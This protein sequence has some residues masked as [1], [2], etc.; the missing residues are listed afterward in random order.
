MKRQVKHRQETLEQLWRT[1]IG[2][3]CSQ[4]TRSD[5][6]LWVHRQVFGRRDK[7]LSRTDWTVQA[8]FGLVIVVL[9]YTNMS[10]N[11]SYDKLYDY[12][13]VH[14]AGLEWWRTP[15]AHTTWGNT[16][17]IP[18]KNHRRRGE[19]ASLWVVYGWAGFGNLG[20]WTAFVVRVVFVVVMCDGKRSHRTSM[21]DDVLCA[22]VCTADSAIRF[23]V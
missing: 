19:L 4:E 11:M 10:Y 3:N 17:Y 7:S 5:T 16:S 9:D 6:S 12:Y 1:L 21:C 22:T 20:R 13:Y 23:S 15:S 2:I 18:K 14:A 8:Q